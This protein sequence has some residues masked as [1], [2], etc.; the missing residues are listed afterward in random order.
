MPP[1]RMQHG[2]TNEVAL[3]DS[4]E[5]GGE[6]TMAMYVVQHVGRICGRHDSDKEWYFTQVSDRPGFY[7]AVRSWELFPV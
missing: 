5:S 4:T 6:R 2:Q 7:S 1:L 3:K